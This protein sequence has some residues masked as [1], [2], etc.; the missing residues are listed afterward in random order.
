M[1]TQNDADNAADF[2]VL[3]KAVIRK[4]YN[5]CM[6]LAQERYDEFKGRGKWHPMNDNRANPHTEG[7]SDGASECAAAIL[8]AF[9]MTVKDL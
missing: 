9:G 5:A 1:N 3:R 8:E 2:D 7:E 4:C 6:D